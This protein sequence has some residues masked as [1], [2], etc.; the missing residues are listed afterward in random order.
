MDEYRSELDEI[1]QDAA[2]AITAA[3]RLRDEATLLRTEARHESARRSGSIDEVTEAR[4]RAGLEVGAAN[5]HAAD[6]Q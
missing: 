6:D 2:R 4:L 3:Q 1:L 5:A